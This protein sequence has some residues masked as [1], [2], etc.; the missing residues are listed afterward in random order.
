MITKVV[1]DSLFKQLNM[2]CAKLCPKQ[3]CNVHMDLQL[4]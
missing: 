3:L 2:T 4:K 1:M